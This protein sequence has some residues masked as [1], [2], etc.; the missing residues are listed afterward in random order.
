MKLETLKDIEKKLL[1]NEDEY[2]EFIVWTSLD[3]RGIFRELKALVVKWVKSE[4]IKHMSGT[5]F[6]FVFAD[7]TEENL[8]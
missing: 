4:R 1:G 2:D 8:K 6:A 3:C 5:D 7:L